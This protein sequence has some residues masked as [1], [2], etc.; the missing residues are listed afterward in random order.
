M[1]FGI[2]KIKIEF[3]YPNWFAFKW[4]ICK[5]IK[6]PKKSLFKAIRRQLIYMDCPISLEH[7]GWYINILGTSIY[8]HTN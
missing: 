4:L 3:D 6:E 5:V 8:I 7:K 2:T 1:I